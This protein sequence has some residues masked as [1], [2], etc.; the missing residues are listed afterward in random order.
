MFGFK[1]YLH[2]GVPE[3]SSGFRIRRRRGEMWSVISRCSR[4]FEF[5]RDVMWVG[6]GPRCVVSSMNKV[7]DA[8]SR[9]AVPVRMI[10]SGDQLNRVIIMVSSAMRLVEGG[11]AMFVRL[12]KSHQVDIRGSRGCNPRMSRRV[13]LCVRS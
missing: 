6:R 11:R 4:V 3:I 8:V 7:Y 1:L 9:V 5:W 13:R 2:R 12:A 10:V